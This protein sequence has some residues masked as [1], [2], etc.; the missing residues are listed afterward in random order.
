MVRYGHG[1]QGH[2][3]PYA[4]E[5]AQVGFRLLHCRGGGIDALLDIEEHLEGVGHLLEGVEED[6]H[7]DVHAVDRPHEVWRKLPGHEEDSL[8]AGLPERRRMS[9]PA[10]LFTRL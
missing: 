7:A 6:P 5:R 10:W 1:A 9:E 3:G 8:H 4:P 2:P